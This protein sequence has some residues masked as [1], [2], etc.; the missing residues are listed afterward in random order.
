MRHHKQPACR[1]WQ[2]IRWFG[3]RRR[4]RGRPCQAEKP[5]GLDEDI[6]QVIET[7]AQRDQVEEIAMLSDGGI[8]LMRNCT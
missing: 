6:R 2:S 8:G 5:A 4:D 3:P 7:A 1:F